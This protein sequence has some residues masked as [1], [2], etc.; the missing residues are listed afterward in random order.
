MEAADHILL[1]DSGGSLES[2]APVEDNKLRAFTTRL[3]RG[4]EAAWMDFHARYFDRL[5]RYLLVLCHGDEQAARDALQTAL[6]RIVRHIRRFDCEEILWSWLTVVARSCVVDESRRRSSYR[7]LLERYALIF[8][9]PLAGPSPDE[10]LPRLLDDC[11]GALP[12]EDRALLAA[13]YHDRVSTADLAARSRCSTKAMES[14]L[15][16]LRSH[17]KGLLLKMLRHEN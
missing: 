12:E 7:A 3:V 16:R 5:L 8:S 13:K 14:R 10:P 4:D 11:L 9:R 1:M 6:V 15:A 17:L 2:A